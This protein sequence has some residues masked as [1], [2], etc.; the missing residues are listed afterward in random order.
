VCCAVVGLLV[1]LVVVDRQVF[2]SAEVLLQEA[3]EGK[4]PKGQRGH[5]YHSSQD[6]RSR[7]LSVITFPVWPKGGSAKGASTSPGCQ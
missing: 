2:P 1:V 3:G 6:R 7:Q 4:R 5:S